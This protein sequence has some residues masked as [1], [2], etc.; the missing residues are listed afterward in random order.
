MRWLRSTVL[1]ESS[2]TA[3]SRRIAAATS[4]GPE[5]RSR[6]T[7]PCWATTWRRSAAREIVVLGVAM[8]RRA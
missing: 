2:C 1:I 5:R 6:V 3:E 4:S 8:A 7:K